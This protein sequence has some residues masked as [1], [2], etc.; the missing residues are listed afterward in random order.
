MKRPVNRALT[1]FI[2][3][4]VIGASHGAAHHFVE[5]PYTAV[6]VAGTTVFVV[7]FIAFLFIPREVFWS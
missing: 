6:L 7:S 3:A 5:S 2:V 1:A 4:S